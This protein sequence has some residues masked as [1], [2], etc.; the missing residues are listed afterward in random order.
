MLFK[1]LIVHVVESFEDFQNDAIAFAL[2]Y[3]ASAALEPHND[4]CIASLHCLASQFFLSSSD[5]M[6]IQPQLSI[7]PRRSKHNNMDD[8]SQSS[9]APSTSFCNRSV[10][11]FKTYHAPINCSELQ[12]TYRYLFHPVNEV[13]E[14]NQ[15]DFRIWSIH[16]LTN[17][18]YSVFLLLSCE[19]P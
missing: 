19:P 7:L 13:P 18:T 11:C 4:C 15:P 9:T 14:T 2:Q 17:M 16:L 6:S 8:A 10:C 5:E 1:H 3:H 12:N